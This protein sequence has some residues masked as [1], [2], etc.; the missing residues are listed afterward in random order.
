MPAISAYSA[1]FLPSSAA[2]WCSVDNQQAPLYARMC[3]CAPICILYGPFIQ[4][5]NEKVTL[6]QGVDFGYQF[7]IMTTRSKF[8]FQTASPVR[9]QSMQNVVLVPQN[10]LEQIIVHI[11]NEFGCCQDIGTAQSRVHTPADNCL[12][13]LPIRGLVTITDRWK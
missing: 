3:R 7:S 10:P 5:S 12:H 11:F 4:L 6:G 8:V 9:E 1:I 2:I 13:S